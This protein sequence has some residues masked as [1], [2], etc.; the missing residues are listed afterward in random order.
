MTRGLTGVKP[1][2]LPRQQHASLLATTASTPK[3]P[4]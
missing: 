3:A 1:A 2:K 4:T